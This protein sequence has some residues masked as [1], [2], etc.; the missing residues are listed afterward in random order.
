MLTYLFNL[1]VR[2]YY[3]FY[4]IGWN[5]LL[6]RKSLQ[7]VNKFFHE[8]CS[9]CN[10]S[11]CT[12]SSSQTGSGAAPKPILNL[13][14][15]LS[16]ANSCTHELPSLI[17]AC[18][19]SLEPQSTFRVYPGFGLCSDEPWNFGSSSGLGGG[20]SGNTGG[21]TSGMS[22]LGTNNFSTG[23]SGA[24][25]GASASP[26]TKRMMSMLDRTSITDVPSA[27]HILV[28]PTSTSASS[29]IVCLNC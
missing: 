19:V 29:L 4:V 18:L 10:I 13:V 25:H 16:G 27:T 20:G 8:R 24:F 22:G 1:C 17:S 12:P 15:S 23:M 9:A 3:N 14:S 26:L 7:E 28:F 6:D 2:N 5:G 11:A 21:G